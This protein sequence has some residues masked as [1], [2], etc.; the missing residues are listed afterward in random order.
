MNRETWMHAL[1]AVFVVLGV[2]ASPVFFA[3]ALACHGL[4]LVRRNP[5]QGI[6]TA[7]LGV[8]FFLVVL[9]YGVGKD[10]ALRDNARASVP[11]TPMGD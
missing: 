5:A 1:I 8:V 11:V 10:M 2:V 7:V 6:V 3:G 9:G 4:L